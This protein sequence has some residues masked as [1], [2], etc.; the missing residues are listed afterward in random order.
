MDGKLTGALAAE[1]ANLQATVAQMEGVLRFT[2]DP[3]T[4]VLL[5]SFVENAKGRIGAIEREA[6]KLASE[7]K[8]VAEQQQGIAAMVER[9]H[10]LNE[11][12][13][14]EYAELLS[15][16]H[17]TRSDFGQLEHFYSHSWDKLTDEGKDEMSHRVWEGVRQGEYQFVEL[18]E[19]VKE[20]EA[21]RMEM[22]LQQ[23]EWSEREFGGIAESDRSDF[24]TARKDGKLEESYQVLNRP[25]F[26]RP[27]VQQ[28]R[29]I[30]SEEVKVD[31]DKVLKAKARSAVVPAHEPDAAPAMGS[32][33]FN[34][35][36]LHEVENA[37]KSVPPPL[38]ELAGGKAGRDRR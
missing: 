15:R 36:E 14:R 16:D 23:A 31:S 24:L 20:K 32:V 8:A 21:Q 2:T 30:S 26:A 35:G 12:E 28:A 38:S 34:L 6:E 33:E 7:E 10:A 25:S 11:A 17:F 5:L 19:V 29:E 1:Y 9:E 18:P 3:A 22:L 13:K 27:S 37:S 4:V